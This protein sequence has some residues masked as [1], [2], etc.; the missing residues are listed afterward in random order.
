MIVVTKLDNKH[1][2]AT[3]W[4]FLFNPFL[5]RIIDKRRFE[6]EFVV[7]NLVYLKLQPYKQTNVTSRKSFKLNP[8]FYNPYRV[9]QKIVVVKATIHPISSIFH[10]AKVRWVWEG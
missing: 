7:G 9:I 2:Y 8:R 10:L 1:N 4:I 5:N 6:W 3:I